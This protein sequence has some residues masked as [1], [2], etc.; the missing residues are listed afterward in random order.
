MATYSDLA[1]ARYLPCNVSLDPLSLLPVL[2]AVPAAVP[3]AATLPRALAS[4]A[5]PS[6]IYLLWIGE[7]ELMA[8]ESV[9]GDMWTEDEAAECC[10]ESDV[11]SAWCEE[12]RARK[13]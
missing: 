13:T 10:V 5:V 12:E 9:D 1:A 2:A 6:T 7:R 11:T 4:D 8:V 3:A